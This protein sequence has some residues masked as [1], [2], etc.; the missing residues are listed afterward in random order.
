MLGTTAAHA[1]KAMESLSLASLLPSES[2]DALA[3]ARRRMAAY[4]TSPIHSLRGAAL[5]AGATTSTTKRSQV[6]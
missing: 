2:S 3:R 4:V 1:A 5:E 6:L